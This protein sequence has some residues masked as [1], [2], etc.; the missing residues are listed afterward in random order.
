M[1]MDKREIED[2]YL[3]INKFFGQLVGVWPYQKQFFKTCIRFVTFTI[4]IFSLATQI[5]RVIVFYSL[6][7]LSD[8][9]P[10]INAGIVTLFKQYNYILNEDKLREL[11]NDI[12]SDRLMERSKEELEILEMYSRRT[13]ALCALYKVMVYS[14]AFMFLV[15]P[16]IPPIL[17]IIAPLNVSRGREFIYPTYYFVD[18]E[19][20]YYPILTHMIAVILVLSSVYLACDTNLVQIVHH[21]CALLAISGYHFKHAVN[22][23]KF[24]DGYYIDASMDETYVKIRQSIKAHKTAVEYVDK[25]D[26]CHIH[27]FLVVIGMIVL[28]FTGTFLKLSTMEV[29]IRFF[30]F[31]AYTIAQ[32]IHLFFLTIMGQFLI[33]ANEETFKT[34]YEAHWYNGSSKMQSLYVLVLRKCLSPPKL[35]G[36]GFV[37][38]NLDSFVQILKASFSYYTV[39]RS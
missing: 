9:L 22:D 6:D 5:S 7:V 26:A 12:V 4:M 38:L 39:F 8:Q 33:N 15:I 37:A 28:A 31:C 18:E 2:Q 29:G 25:I 20:Y 34:I 36:G 13:T 3:K 24:C 16:T 17:N 23:V 11:L 27:Y 19:K 21:G 1:I 30:T 14:C 10:Y 32:L 35:T